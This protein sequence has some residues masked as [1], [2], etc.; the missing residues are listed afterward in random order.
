MER[1]RRMNK[2]KD[3][4]QQILVYGAESLGYKIPCDPIDS[5]NYILKFGKVDTEEDLSDYDGVIF[6]AN[7]FENSE[8]SQI[9]CADKG[10][11]LKRIKQLNKLL[12]KGGFVSVL[13]Y[14]LI[15]EYTTFDYIS[16]HSHES[17]DTSLGK[18]LLNDLG[19]DKWR[20]KY[21]KAPLKHFK[22][23]RDEFKS[24]LADYGV[25]QTY[26]E[27]YGPGSQIKP[28]CTLNNNHNFVGLIFNDSIF[29]L[30]CHAVDKDEK[31]TVK[32]FDTV[33]K[34][35]VS[36]LPKLAQEIPAWVDRDLMFNKEKE[37]LLEL[38]KQTGILSNIETAI[39]GYKNFK[40]ALIF[41]SDS[42]VANV[43][44]VLENFFQIKVSRIE[45]YKED[46]KLLQDGKL[47]AIAEVKGVNS[48][49]Q[50]EHI[51]QVDSHRERQGLA[52]DFPALLIINTKMAATSLKDK[53]IPV[54][55]EQIKKAVNDRVLI[56]R[57]LDLLNLIK[58]VETSKISI[59]EILKI[60]K[61][62][63]GWL[64][65]TEETFEIMKE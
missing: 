41:G 21:S 20:R 3:N 16:S 2:A 51:N 32:L 26:F 39:A 9:Y 6:F 48:G 42:L 57:T 27:F 37:L 15:D 28:I 5:S 62:E 24:Y 46:L 49:V 43:G 64:K 14:K 11:M 63:H 29:I 12:D 8:Q 25:A 60:F 47:I 23:F 59:D 61:N 31:S 52:S 54:A 7:T 50:R 33:A 56:V 55:S 40:G 38:K 22:L 65:A 17:F 36:T 35:I 18:V 30:P 13:T 58:L 44:Y 10:Q 19:I 45:E 34:G 4:R 53:D 1:H